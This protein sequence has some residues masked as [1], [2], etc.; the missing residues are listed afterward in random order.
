MSNEWWAKK[1]GALATPRPQQPGPAFTGA[2]WQEP[3]QYQGS[4]GNPA[5]PQHVALQAQMPYGGPAGP[6]GVPE[7][8]YV[9][10]LQ[11]VPTEDLTQDQMETIAAWELRNKAKYNQVCPQC[12][13]ANFAPAG[14][15]LGNST[16]GTDK[17][18][19]CGGSH[20]TY[21]SSPE[22]ASGGRGTSGARR[23]DVRQ[24]D[25]GG[26]AGSMYLKLGNMPASY[27]P[28]GG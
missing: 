12:R 4:N 14:T 1:I 21:T 3:Q 23:L 2:W 22:P 17:C 20:S 27:V 15:R 5:I 26:A 8:Q 9:R 16:L 18:F 11:R 10:Q 7:E 13:S 19:D 6:Q 24:I 25:T 28:R